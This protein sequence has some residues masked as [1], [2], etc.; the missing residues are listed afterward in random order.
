MNIYSINTLSVRL[1]RHKCINI[2]LYL[3]GVRFST[4]KYILLTLFLFLL[5][6]FFFKQLRYLRMLSSL[7]NSIS[8]ISCFVGIWSDQQYTRWF[9]IFRLS[10][11]NTS[12]LLLWAGSLNNDTTVTAATTAAAT[13]AATNSSKDFLLTIIGSLMAH[14]HKPICSSCGGLQPF[15][16]LSWSLS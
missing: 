10:G 6:V 5:S 1:Q 12:T 2:I 7:L 15:G 3:L 4:F 16:T 11:I 8:C 13:A 14:P 9:W